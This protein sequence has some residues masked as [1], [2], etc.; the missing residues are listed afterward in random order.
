MRAI[1]STIRAAAVPDP[2]TKAPIGLEQFGASLG[3]AIKKD[4][5]FYFVNY[6]GQ[7]YNVA[8]SLITTPPVTVAC[9]GGSASELHKPDCW[10][11]H[12]PRGCLQ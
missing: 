1:S 5:L 4:K 9:L 11:L 10:R 7:R 6:E 2:C 8:D 12:E 3:G